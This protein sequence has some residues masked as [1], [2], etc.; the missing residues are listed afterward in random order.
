MLQDAKIQAL[1]LTLLTIAMFDE[2]WYNTVII[3]TKSVNE[4]EKDFDY[5]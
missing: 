3:M 5:N 1:Y 4:I 2:L